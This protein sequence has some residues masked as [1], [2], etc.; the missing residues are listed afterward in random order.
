MSAQESL[1]EYLQR[2]APEIKGEPYEEFRK[3]RLSAKT[4]Y[5]KLHP[6]QPKPA[7][8]EKPAPETRNW[9]KPKGRNR[10]AG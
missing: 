9:T 4:A 5:E 1:I 2:E 7:P 8:Q 10:R 6:N 3:R